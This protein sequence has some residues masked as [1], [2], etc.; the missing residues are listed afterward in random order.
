M[1]D[2]TPTQKPKFLCDQHGQ[3]SSMRLMCFMSF[4]MA[5]FI[6][7]FHITGASPERIEP[8]HMLEWG[9][10]FLVGAFAPKAI[11][12]AV[13]K[14]VGGQIRRQKKITT[15]SIVYDMPTLS[16]RRLIASVSWH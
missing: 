11:Q 16:R 5:C 12:V 8:L 3:P 7:I 4:L 15:I 13:E 9:G 14:W 6:C 1:T 2:P 10:I